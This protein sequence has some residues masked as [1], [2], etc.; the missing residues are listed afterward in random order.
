MK[1]LLLTTTI[2]VGLSLWFSLIPIP[3]GATTV[4]T[5]PSG[6]ASIHDILSVSG[7]FDSS[8]LYLGA[9]FQPGT[10][11]SSKL[12]FWWDLDTDLNP[13]TGWPMGLGTD[14]YV[15]FNSLSNTTYATVGTPLDGPIGSVS[16]SFSTNSLNLSVPLSL[17]GGS[18][19]TANFGLGVGVQ[20]GSNQFILTDQAPDADILG[21][22]TSPV[23]GY[24]PPIA[25][26]ASILRSFLEFSSIP[27]RQGL[28]DRTIDIY[29]D[30]NGDWDAAQRDLQNFNLDMVSKARNFALDTTP[31]TT[32]INPIP[33]SDLG[34]LAWLLTNAK[35]I[36]EFGVDF[37]LL[38]LGLLPQSDFNVLSVEG[39]LGSF[40]LDGIHYDR[41]KAEITAEVD[42]DLLP[43]LSPGTQ[44]FNDI[45]LFNKQKAVGVVTITNVIDPPEFGTIVMSLEQVEMTPVPEPATMLLLGSG[46]IGLAGY[47]R[48][49][50][51]K[52]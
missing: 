26:Q 48:K 23:P 13:N 37:I 17:L 2:V 9:N 6:D 18:N 35:R 1:K 19:G 45:S 40:D 38:L 41:I 50:F 36:V 11:N 10:L 49:R 29:S 32:T 15:S 20:A 24:T 25:L 51:F 12:S 14:Y 46:L 28:M 4:I 22:P 34:L 27:N 44:F 43:Y 30:P 52:K 7:G 33:T 5:D 3:I 42:K 21:G 39:T 47:G 8:N 16:V 31:L